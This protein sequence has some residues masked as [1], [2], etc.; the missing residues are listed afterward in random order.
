MPYPALPLTLFPSCTPSSIPILLPHYSASLTH[1]YPLC[2]LLLAYPISL[3][4]SNSQPITIQIYYSSPFCTSPPAYTTSSHHD[5]YP[6]P[7]H[8][9][10]Y[11]TPIYEYPPYFHLFSIS[12]YSHSPHTQNPCPQNPAYSPLHS[13]LSYDTPNP[14]HFNLPLSIH[15]PHCHSTLPTPNPNAATPNTPI[16]PLWTCS[17]H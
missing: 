4:P 14:L 10:S 15:T 9:Q 1:H 7:P 8:P 16:P 13:F 3:L 5:T 12:T 6:N 2:P 11:P 17:H